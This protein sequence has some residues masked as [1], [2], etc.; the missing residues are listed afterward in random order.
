MPPFSL[1]QA[2]QERENK[3]GLLQ[4]VLFCL[5][6][7]MNDA[8]PTKELKN[9]SCDSSANERKPNL[10]NMRHVFEHQHVVPIALLMFLQHAFDLDGGRV[11]YILAMT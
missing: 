11:I 3:A 8:S 2:K 5:T 4:R 1:L 10:E 7:H 6:C 9:R